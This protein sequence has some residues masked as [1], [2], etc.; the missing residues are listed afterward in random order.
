M[1]TPEEPPQLTRRQLRELRNTAS[2]PIVT[3]A[4]TPSE[5]PATPLPRAAEPVVLAEPPRA[6]PRTSAGG[7]PTLTRREVRQ[8]ERL[9]TA[10][11]PVITAEVLAATAA[12]AEARAAEEQDRIDDE[13]IVDAE[14]VEVPTE[15]ET[16]EPEAAEPD[17]AEPEAAE[18]EA[19][20]PE[21]SS[22]DVV[23]EAEPVDA[24]PSEDEPE[25][26]DASA[27]QSAPEAEEEPERRVIAPDFGSELLRGQPAE[28]EVPASFDQLLTRGSTATGALSMPNALIL[29]QT[30]DGGGFTSPVTATGEVLITGTF[31]LPDRYGSTGAVPG[32]SDGTDVDAVLIDGEL[33]AASSPTPIA[34]SAAISTIKSADE[35]IKPPAPE[36]GSRLMVVLAITAGVLAV[37]LAGVLILAITTGVF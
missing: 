32:R 11:V 27:S 6:E 10:S 4:P 23:T 29:S 5:P 34:A 28:V 35:I 36:K 26:A 3:D 25:P 2:T 18:P 17:T 16:V 30:P 8:R 21:P 31:A 20:E 15:P 33:P 7:A 37:A 14:L 9:R 19:A 13:M 22:P 24:A 1:S 12:E